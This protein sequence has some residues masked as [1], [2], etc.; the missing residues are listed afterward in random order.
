MKCKDC[1]YCELTWLERLLNRLDLAYCKAYPDTKANKIK[2]LL[3]HGKIQYE[4]CN[5]IR[6]FEE[7]DD[8]CS[9]FK[10]K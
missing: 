9:K 8:I 7:K 5:V 1:K 6:Q 4:L 3:G 2:V 10:G